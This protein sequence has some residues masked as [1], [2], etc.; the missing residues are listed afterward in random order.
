MSEIGGT[1]LPIQNVRSPVAN[2]GKADNI[3]SLRDLPVLTQLC[4]SAINFAVMHSSV[5]TQRCGNVWAGLWRRIHEASRVHHAAR[6][7]GGCMAAS[8][9]GAAAEHAA[10]RRASARGC[11]RSG[12]SGPA[13]GVP[14]GA[15][16]LGWTDGRNVRIDTRWGGGRSDDIR[17]HAAELVALAPDVILAHGASTVGPLLQATRTVPIVFAIVG[18]PVG[19]GFV[20]SLARPGGNATGF[21][22]IEYSLS[23]K[24]LELLKQIAPSVTRA[25]VLR[26]P[27][28]PPGPASLPSSSPW[29]RRSGWK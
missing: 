27:A 24:W 5:L 26:D 15:A 4:H 22:T 12:I 25:A 7:R 20:D 9:A 23:G 1:K 2:G 17:R 28:K 13:R 21:M 16:E 6:R 18:D 3:C 29:R 10:H 19:A 8:G 11:G 14:A